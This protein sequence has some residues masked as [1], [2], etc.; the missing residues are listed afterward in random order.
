MAHDVDL[1]IRGGLVV[2]GTGAEP[3]EADV[4]VADGRIVA[5]GKVTANTGAVLDAKASGCM[6]R[7]W[8]MICRAAGDA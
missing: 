7:R 3:L 1:L 2:D 6:R 8:R 4:A 5:V